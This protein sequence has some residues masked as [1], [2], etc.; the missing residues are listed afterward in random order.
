M[1]VPEKD[2]DL[3]VFSRPTAT[4]PEIRGLGE[5]GIDVVVLGFDG[6]GFEGFRVGALSERLGEPRIGEAG[7]FAKR[8][9][10]GGVKRA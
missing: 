8:G 10:G 7:L 2:F 5:G 9:L 1:D 6:V 4:W 3:S